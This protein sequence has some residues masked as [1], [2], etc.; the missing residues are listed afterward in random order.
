MQGEEISSEVVWAVTGSEKVSISKTGVLKIEK[1]TVGVTITVTATANGRTAT[2]TFT[3][4]EAVQSGSSCSS[5]VS[6]TALLS[7]AAVLTAFGIVF[8][9]KRKNNVVKGGEINE[10]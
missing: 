3:V 1:G 10:K 2:A 9:F 4:A 6:N 8:F 5:S 7:T